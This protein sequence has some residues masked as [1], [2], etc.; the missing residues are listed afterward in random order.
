VW[1]IVAGWEVGKSIRAGPFTVRLNLLT[2]LI[3]DLDV[4]GFAR[5]LELS[6]EMIR[7]T[8]Q[9]IGVYVSVE[10]FK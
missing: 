10:T 5:G 9:S 6:M 2:V 3:L 1:H 4:R 8:I 7:S